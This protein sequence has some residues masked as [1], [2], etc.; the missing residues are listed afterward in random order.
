VSAF[1][2]LPLSFGLGFRLCSRLF[3]TLADFF[4]ATLSVFDFLGQPACFFFSF[5]AGRFLG[6]SSFRFFFSV[7]AGFFGAQLCLGDFVGQAIRIG[8]G[9]LA[10]LG[11][12]SAAAGVIFRALTRRCLFQFP[13]RLL[14]LG[15]LKRFFFG[16][17]TSFFEP[18]IGFGNFKL[19]FLSFFFG[20][21]TR[22]FFFA[23]L[24]RF[25][26]AVLRFLDFVGQ[27]TGFFFR[28]AAGRFLGCPSFRFFFRT[29]ARFLSTPLG[30][31]NLFRQPVGFRSGELAGSILFAALERHFFGPPPRLFGLGLIA[32]GHLGGAI[33]RFFFCPLPSFVCPALC[34][35]YFQQKL[36]RFFFRSLARGGFFS[37][38]AGF[39]V[40]TQTR[41]FGAALDFGEFARQTRCLFSHSFP[42]SLVLSSFTRFFSE[43]LFLCLLFLFAARG[44]FCDQLASS[45]LSPLAGRFL[46]R[47]FPR[48]LLFRLAAGSLLF[49]FSLR[50][51]FG[52]LP[53]FIGPP[54]G[55]LEFALQTLGFLF[56]VLLPFGQNLLLNGYFRQS[57]GAR[58]GRNVQA[59]NRGHKRRI[60]RANGF[61]KLFE[62]NV[63]RLVSVFA[64][65]GERSPHNVF[66][67]TRNFNAF[68]R[69]AGRRLSQMFL[70][71]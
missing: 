57:D 46:F 63:N 67:F 7:F 51:F 36:A 30:F 8:G 50:G 9:A 64:V 49:S 32:R 62:K 25:F 71:H 68:F 15:S 43:A 27:A 28:L 31:G 42:L 2:F 59:G 6:C 34:F 11:F 23:P 21:F 40:G 61:A 60:H 37:S 66:N 17:L 41:L 33:L 16:S 35:L 70:H 45:F 56:E 18:L 13:A 38:F 53:S 47:K 29:L 55:L 26:D 58:V 10:G 54:L 14:F 19:E 39:F 48:R 12:F 3:G 22:R 69:K 20:V 65:L 52:P 4:H 44:F 24:A 5:P 1:G